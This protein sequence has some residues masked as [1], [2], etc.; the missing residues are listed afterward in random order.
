MNKI[1]ISLT[2]DKDVYEQIK[3]ISEEEERKVSQQVNK[4]L[5]EYLKGKE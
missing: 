2:L 4:V 3:Q 1:K 5:K